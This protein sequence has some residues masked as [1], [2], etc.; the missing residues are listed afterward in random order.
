[1]AWP[2]KSKG[3]IVA[4]FRCQMFAEMLRTGR[5]LAAPESMGDQDDMGKSTGRFLM[6]AADQPAADTVPVFIN[7]KSFLRDAMP[8]SNLKV[9]I[10]YEISIAEIARLENMNDS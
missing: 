3:C 7:I 6:V 5:I 8:L 2:V 9:C 1:M 4:V 10:R